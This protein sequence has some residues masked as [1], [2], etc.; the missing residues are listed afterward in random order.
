MDILA[1][2]NAVSH[3]LVDGVCVSALFSYAVPVDELVMAVL[4]YNTMAFTT[5]C[6]FGLIL[7]NYCRGKFS[8][9]ESICFHGRLEALSMLIVALG[10]WL[11]V[12]PVIKAVII[13]LGNSLFH[14]CGGVVTLKKSRGKAAPL[15]VFVAPGAFGVT[16]GTVFPG[17]GT[18][19]AA[20]LTAASVAC[21]MLYQSISKEAETESGI[22]SPE[23]EKAE[24]A[25][26]SVVML[27]LAV[28]VRAV[29]GCAVDFSWKSGALHAFIMTLF[30]FLGKSLGGFFC[31][32]FGAVRMSVVTV[33][34]ATVFTA[35]FAWNMPLSLSGQMLLNLSMP[36]TLWLLFRK[37][38]EE[39]GLAF[40]LAA[41]ALWPGTI[42]GQLIRLSGPPQKF[43]IIVC[44]VFS[45][46]A[47]I[48]AE[49]GE[50]RQ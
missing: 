23:A 16:L 33:S 28:A 42:A 47:I 50:K 29:G 48:Y 44:F 27:T 22:I 39:P 25:M 10:F 3:F 11:P 18:L 17:Y 12:T 14:V 41:S 36:V 43:L 1:L 8:S 49:R 6:V 9:K 45:L 38:P 26:L 30:V 32:R 7:D 2:I 46:V 13:G 15:G 21:I 4:V 19:L 37:M 34:L 35:F 5:Q 20:A 31:D 40:G 24:P